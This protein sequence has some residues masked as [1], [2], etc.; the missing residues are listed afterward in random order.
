[1]Q[2]APIRV[3]MLCLHIKGDDFGDD[4]RYT[5]HFFYIV[6]IKSWFVNKNTMI[7][8]KASSFLVIFAVFNVLVVAENANLQECENSCPKDEK[9]SQDFKDCIADCVKKHA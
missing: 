6:H 1:M 7:F 8:F 2:S 5:Y 3:K 9:D 4:Y